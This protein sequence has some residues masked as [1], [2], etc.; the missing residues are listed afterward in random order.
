MSCNLQLS[1]TGTCAFLIFKVF[2]FNVSPIE[3]P[4]KIV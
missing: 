2:I 4:V 1:T 3:V